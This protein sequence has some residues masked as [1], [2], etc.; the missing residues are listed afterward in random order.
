VDRVIENA[1]VR[2]GRELADGISQLL[3]DLEEAPYQVDENIRM[4]FGCEVP[5]RLTRD[6]RENGLEE[7]FENRPLIRLIG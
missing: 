7:R 1:F 4:V 6:S 3:I 2:V 5:V